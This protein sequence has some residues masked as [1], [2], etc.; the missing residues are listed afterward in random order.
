[1]SK[2]HPEMSRRFRRRERLPAQVFRNPNELGYLFTDAAV[3]TARDFWMVL[4]GLAR[5][6]EEERVV[7]EVIEDRQAEGNASNSDN[8]L[9]PFEA[10]C[11]ASPAALRSW[12]NYVAPTRP[13]ALYIYA[14]VVAFAGDGSIWGVWCDQDNELCILGVPW[15][16]LGSIRDWVGSMIDWPLYDA[17]EID[18]LLAPASYPENPPEEF[19]RR[20]R[21]SFGSART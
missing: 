11:D 8:S 4:S 20:I 7:G 15:E 12:L 2:P 1:M 13:E 10:K 18:A 21:R 14:R 3:L 6:F 17:T 19:L 9:P 16:D 5:K